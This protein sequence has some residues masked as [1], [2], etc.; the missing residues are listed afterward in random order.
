M[1]Y[2]ETSGLLGVTFSQ[3]VGCGRNSPLC[4][5]DELQLGCCLDWQESLGLSAVSREGGSHL[6]KAP[7]SA[8]HLLSHL[9][10]VLSGSPLEGVP[11]LENKVRPIMKVFRK[12]SFVSLQCS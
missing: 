10:V 5:R 3:L 4:P 11:M 9:V 2:S 7:P 1:D 12:Q 8:S 6:S